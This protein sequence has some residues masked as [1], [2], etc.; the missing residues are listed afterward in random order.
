[1]KMSDMSAE[2]DS[3]E[4]RVMN[5]TRNDR[6]NA[7]M[8]TRNTKHQAPNQKRKPMKSMRSRFL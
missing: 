2:K 5:L 8:S 1:M 3:S 4:K 7:T 6:S